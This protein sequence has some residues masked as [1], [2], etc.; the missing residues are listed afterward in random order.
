MCQSLFLKKF[1]GLKP[2]TSLLLKRRLCYRC[3]PVNVVKV[4]RAPFLWNTSGQLLLHYFSTS[5]VLFARQNFNHD[6]IDTIIKDA[7]YEFTTHICTV[8]LPLD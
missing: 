7:M 8:I 5:F 1:S 4:L 3:F 6:I 2:A